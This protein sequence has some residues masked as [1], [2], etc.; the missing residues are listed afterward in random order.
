MYIVINGLAPNCLADLF[1]SKKHTT[2]Y[3]LRGSFTS[4]QLPLP[5]TEYQ[6]KRI[7][8]SGAKLWN[9]LPVALRESETPSYL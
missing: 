4:L 2:R 3:S 9:S 5:N 8:Y 7:C 1:S 6:K